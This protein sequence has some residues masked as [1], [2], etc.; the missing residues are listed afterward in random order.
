M[1]VSQL[2]PRGP[3]RSGRRVGAGVDSRGTRQAGADAGSD[4]RDVDREAPC[5]TDR[6]SMVGSSDVRGGGDGWT[7]WPGEPI[8]SAAE[9]SSVKTAAIRGVSHMPRCMMKKC[10]CASFKG[11]EPTRQRAADPVGF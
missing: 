4:A 11:N 1:R 7:I 10:S 3:S 8:A 2:I 6:G 5:G 9:L